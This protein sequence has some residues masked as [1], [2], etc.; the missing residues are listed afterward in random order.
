MFVMIA[1]RMFVMIADRMS[2]STLTI[3]VYLLIVHY[4][5]RSLDQLTTGS[6]HIISPST[7]YFL[8]RTSASV[9]VIESD[10]VHLHPDRLVSDHISI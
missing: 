3:I 8:Y 1:D 4:S 6:I 2:D 5:V 10:I 7:Y 9:G